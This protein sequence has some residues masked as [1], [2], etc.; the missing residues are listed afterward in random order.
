MN[1]FSAFQVLSPWRNRIKVEVM[2]G[3]VPQPVP[4][5]P[6]RAN[7]APARLANR[8]PEAGGLRLLP[9]LRVP[10]ADLGPGCVAGQW[11]AVP[12]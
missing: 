2:A 3:I 12:S 5:A 8:A 11:R 9:Y 6:A 1:W 10:A 4:T 7:A